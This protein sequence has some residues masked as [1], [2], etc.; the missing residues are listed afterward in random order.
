[1]GGAAATGRELAENLRVHPDAIAAHVA[2]SSH[3]LLSEAQRFGGAS[4]PEDY[5]GVSDTF[6]TRL[7][8]AAREELA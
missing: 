4:A 5:L 8:A 2:V 1:V 3:D 6:T 7:I